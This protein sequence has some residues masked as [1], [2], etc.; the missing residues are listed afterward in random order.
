MEETERNRLAWKANEIR[1]LILE[2]IGK[3][4]VGHIGGSLSIVEALTV[5]YYKHMAVDPEN[6]LWDKRD[7]FVLSKGHG[8]PGLYAVLADKGYFPKAWLDTLNKPNTNLPSHCDRLKTPGVDMTA[9]SLAQGFSAAVG[10]ALAAQ[11]DGR[12]VRVYAII[13]DGESQEGQIW[14]AAMFA[15]NRHLDNMITFLDYNNMQIDGLVSEINSLEP[16]A[17]KWRAFGWNVYEVDGHDVEA[18]DSAVVLGKRFKGKPTMIVLNTTKGK[19]AYFCEGKVSSHNMTIT[20]EQWREA[21]DRLRKESD[22]A[23]S[24]EG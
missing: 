3:L 12:G 7:R 11:M 15:G 10:M 9:G 13:G 2:M 21:V 1:Q 8:G 14:E 4:G 23:S 20:D 19:G 5:L 22:P 18:V 16:V 17:E 6:P 24:C